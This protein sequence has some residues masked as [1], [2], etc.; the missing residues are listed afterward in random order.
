MASVVTGDMDQ[1]AAALGTF[2]AAQA[3]DA[4]AARGRF[5]VALSGGSLPKTLGKALTLASSSG[6]TMEW[7]KWTIVF[8]DERVVPLDD[9]DSNYKACGAHVF[10][11]GAVGAAIP[12]ANV[13]AIDASLEPEECAV[14]YAKALAAA[15]PAREGDAGALPCIDL[16]LLGMGPDGHTCSLFPSHPLLEEATLTVASIADSPKPPPKRITLTYPVLNASR[17]VAF[18]CGG[19]G[20]KESLKSVFESTSKSDTGALPSARVWPA[21]GSLTWFVD[22]AAAALCTPKIIENWI[23]AHS[24]L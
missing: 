18:V 4:V 21:N 2:V 9:D 24:K 20:K 19:D 17:A 15:A 23:S 3:A 13:I 11:E 22:N 14:A 5:V 10:G 16:V 7:D 6:A 8:A 1:L 12:A